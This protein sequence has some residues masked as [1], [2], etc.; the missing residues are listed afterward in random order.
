MNNKYRS[1]KKMNKENLNEE[2]SMEQVGMLMQAVTAL[3]PQ[4]KT[5][6]LQQAITHGTPETKFD[7]VISVARTSQEEVDYNKG[8]KEN[9]PTEPSSWEKTGS[10]THYLKGSKQKYNLAVKQGLPVFHYFEYITEVEARNA[11]AKKTTAGDVDITDFLKIGSEMINEKGS[12]TFDLSDGGDEEII[13]SGNGLFL[14][15]RTA[16]NNQKELDKSKPFIKMNVVDMKSAKADK[17]GEFEDSNF[18]KIKTNSD[19]QSMVKEYVYYLFTMSSKE[20]NALVQKPAGNGMYYLFEGSHGQG[21]LGIRDDKVSTFKTGLGEIVKTTKLGSERDEL[22][23]DALT[24]QLFLMNDFL[25]PLNKDVITQNLADGKFNIM[26]RSEI[27]SYL[28]KFDEAKTENERDQVVIDF[29]TEAM[30]DY[31]ENFLNMVDTFAKDMNI[32]KEVILKEFDIEKGV[33]QTV[34]VIKQMLTSKKKVIMRAGKDSEVIP[35]A[36]DK[37]KTLINKTGDKPGTTTPGALPF[38]D[39]ETA[40]TVVKVGE[41]KYQIRTKTTSDQFR[42]V[43]IRRATGIKKESFRYLKTFEGFRRSKKGY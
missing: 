26:D 25:F 20:Y 39:I 18:L 1:S 6:T 42:D 28:N 5:I 10:P 16:A 12:M 35:G 15:V 4:A 7:I 11:G 32:S 9:L 24:G 19:K 37:V 40:E 3:G 8:I 33:N 30:S 13:A 2:I 41:T 36:F 21:S 27:Q 23:K 14:L 34:N 31:K 43:E 17:S 22:V 38:K 29:M